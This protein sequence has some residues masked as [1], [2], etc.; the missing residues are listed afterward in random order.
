MK[1]RTRIS[2][3]ATLLTHTAISLRC[4][5]IVSIRVRRTE[6]WEAVHRC[7]VNAFSPEKGFGWLATDGLRVST[8]RPQGALY[9]AVC[10]NGEA[11]FR[12]TGLRSGVHIITIVTGVGLEGA[13]PFSVSCNGRVVASDLSIAPLMVQTLSFPV[14]LESGEALFTFTGNWAISTL[15]DQL[16]QTSYEDYSFRRGLASY[17][18]PEPS[19]IFSSVLRQG[20]GIHGSCVEVSL[21]GAGS[22][23]GAPLKS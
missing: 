6:I 9:S 21:A 13:G 5:R 17:R 2:P 23:N 7:G 1:A 18:L 8:H 4:C 12:M 14:W 19:V 11:S 16:L 3:V 20:A 15:N 22:G 10:G